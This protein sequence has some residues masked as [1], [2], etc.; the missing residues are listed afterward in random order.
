M[1]TIVLRLLWNVPNKHI[2]E[3][4]RSTI[5]VVLILGA[6]V[7]SRLIYERSLHLSDTF[8]YRS[9]H[10]NLFLTLRVIQK[11]KT[12]WIEIN[13]SQP[14]DMTFCPP[15]RKDVFLERSVR[16]CDGSGKCKINVSYN[17]DLRSHVIAKQGNGSEKIACRW[18]NNSLCQ[19]NMSP[20][21]YK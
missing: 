10:N 18:Q 11:L 17:F 3:R 2:A 6:F 1:K 5:V 9:A 8:A 20:W 13:K 21:F 7:W 16:V 12:T 4:E 14:T 15:W 19:T